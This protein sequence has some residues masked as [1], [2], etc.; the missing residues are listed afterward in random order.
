MGIGIDAV[1]FGQERMLQQLPRAPPLGRVTPQALVEEV[2]A[3]LGEPRREF[4]QLRPVSDEEHEL[5]LAAPFQPVP[6][7][8]AAPRGHL[9]HGA[10][11]GPDVGLRHGPLAPRYLRRHPERRAA[12]ADADADAPVAFVVPHSPGRAEVGELGRPRRGAQKDVPA[13]DVGMHHPGDG[14]EVVQSTR[15]AAGVGPDVGLPQPGGG[16]G[17]VEQRAAEE[18][19][20]VQIAPD[21]RGLP[22]CGVAEVGDYV[23]G[24]E[25]SEDSD[26]L[27]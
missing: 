21:A 3:D 20:H 4:R 16:R 12:A 19:L 26:L 14:V 23:G 17:A 27:L 15:H 8:L 25:G 5:R 18:A 24:G 2:P 22:C 9:D 6:P 7:R 13:L 10:P 11:E 1:G